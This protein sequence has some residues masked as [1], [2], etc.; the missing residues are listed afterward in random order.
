ML[1]SRIDLNLLNMFEAVYSAQSVTAAAKRLNLSQSAVSHSLSRLR[2]EFDDPLF[3]RM[4]NAL[5]PTAL[6]RA[7]AEPIRDALRGVNIALANAGQFAPE[8]SD[9]LFRIGLRPTVEALFSK[10]DAPHAQR[11]AARARGQRG[12][13]AGAPAAIAGRS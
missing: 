9:R 2:R 1:R 5:V 11:S 12:F 3:V 7:L 6:A 10:T 4:G 8:T 13:P